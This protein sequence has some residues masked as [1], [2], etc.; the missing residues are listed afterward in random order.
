MIGKFV[1]LKNPSNLSLI[2]NAKAIPFIFRRD[3]NNSKIPRYQNTYRLEPYKRWNFKIVDKILINRMQEYLANWK[4]EPLTCVEMC[5][6]ISE[7][8]R[9]KI[10]KLCYD[11]YKI[12][13]IISIVQKLEQGVRMDFGKLCDHQ[14]DTYSTYVIETTKYV[15][16]GLVVGIYYD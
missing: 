14:R 9:D 12:L 15:A 3:K 7:D 5:Q 8:V 6:K 1:H 16:M 4:Y 2:R 13:V 10:Y 11:R